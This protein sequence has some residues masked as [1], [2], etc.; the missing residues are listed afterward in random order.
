M[1][2]ITMVAHSSC[3]PYGLSKY[4]MYIEN[5]KLTTDWQGPAIRTKVYT[6][7]I[8]ERG[9]VYVDYTQYL[10]VPYNE[11]GKEIKETSKGRNVDIKA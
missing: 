9:K 7:K 4:I 1:V 11:R 8:D 2:P 5:I 3:H 10:Y 6:T